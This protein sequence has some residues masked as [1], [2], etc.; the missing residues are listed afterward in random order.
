MLDVV[1]WELQ[2]DP[3]S[4]RTGRAARPGVPAGPEAA[5]MR[6]QRA[7]GNRA[8]AQLVARSRPQLGERVLAR[9]PLD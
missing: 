4:A 5:V 3:V 1:G 9:D 7:A 6:L 2:R 8:A